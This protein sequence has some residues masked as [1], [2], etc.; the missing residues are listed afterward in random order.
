MKAK[1]LKL[2]VLTGLFYGK[3]SYAQVTV[4]NSGLDADLYSNAQALGGGSTVTGYDDWFFGNTGAGMGMIDTTGA[5]SLNSFFQSGYGAT[6]DQSFSKRSAY[7]FWHNLNGNLYL[8]GG[9]HRDNVGLM[10]STVFSGG[11][12]NGQSM[13]DYNGAIATVQPKSDI[14]DIYTAIRKAGTT[15]NDSLWLFGGVAILGTTGSRFFDFEFYQTELKYDPSTTLF[16]GLGPDA[17]RTRWEFNGSGEV[18]K[19]GDL[20]LACEFDNTGLISMELRIWVSKTDFNNV[21]PASFSWGT[22]WD[23]ANGGSTYGYGTVLSTSATYM[24]FLNTSAVTGPPWGSKSD[25]SKYE[26]NYL[27]NQFLEFGLNLTSIGIDPKNLPQFADPCKGVVNTFMAKTRSSASFT[28]ALNDF[29]NPMQFAAPELTDLTLNSSDTIFTCYDDNQY[30]IHAS[31]DNSGLYSDVEW[32]WSTDNGTFS[33]S[34]LHQDSVIIADEGTYY[35]SIAK[36]SGCDADDTDTIDVTM[37][38]EPPYAT[39][40]IELGSIAPAGTLA[41]EGGDSATSVALTSSTGFGPSDGIAWSWDGP[42]GFTST[43]KD[44]IAND[45]GTF[46]LT[47]TEIRNG[48]TDVTTSTIM[49]LPVDLLDFTAKMNGQIVELNWATASERNSSKFIV[50]RS[51]DMI[52]WEHIDDLDAAG[53]SYQVVNYA[54]LDKEPNKGI[55]YYRLLQM[56]NDGSYEYSKAIS[57]NNDN[58]I[59]RVELFPNPV[60][61]GETLRINS[62]GA[63]TVQVI[64]SMGAVV[65]EQ[66]EVSGEYIK[67][68][69]EEFVAGLYYVRIQIGAEVESRPLLIKE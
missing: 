11:D 2:M 60:K 48:C 3:T 57:V 13:A 69:T 39:V 20:I 26:A 35:V 66:S 9:Y 31:S 62:L 30:I 40:D 5:S 52:E 29:T 12:K 25:S 49:M 15:V 8:V 23:G 55:T 28:S 6:Y 38:L 46:T 54:S 53:Y 61:V 50:Q 21:T 19:V 16:T 63:E 36:Y 7:G 14:I 24:S 1:F 68:L 59:S 32:T 27:T 37:D 33:S 41:I 44:I 10:D 34:D 18:T 58:E 67:I 65:Y 64:N 22:N 17:G 43:D 45:S 47:V 51:T 42:S 4:A 56:D